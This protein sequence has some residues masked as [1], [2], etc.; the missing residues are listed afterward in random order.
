MATFTF[1]DEFANI[2]GQGDH[3]FDTDTFKMYLTN[4]AVDQAT[5][6]VAADHTKI[7]ANGGGEKTLTVTWAETGGGT[8][9]WRFSIA[10]D[11]VWTASG[12]SFGPFR[13]VVVY[14]DTHASDALVG[15]LDYGSAITVNDTETF[16]ADVDA[17]FTLFTITIS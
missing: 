15:Y 12:G 17:N 7:S 2:L 16:T 10:A 8:G 14:N 5:N 13:Y 4:T 6:T 11:Q 9:V 3:H 1:F